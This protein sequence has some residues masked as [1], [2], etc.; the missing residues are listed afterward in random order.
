MAEKAKQMDEA[1]VLIEELSRDFLSMKG[2]AV[3]GK[4]VEPF[5]IS[6]KPVNQKLWQ[7][8]MGFNPSSTKGESLPVDRISWKECQKF[9]NRINEIDLFYQVL[10]R[11]HNLDIHRLAAICGDNR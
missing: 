6:S 8:I 4:E 5:Y 3:S 9:I 2:G 11:W 10:L 7:V 1:K